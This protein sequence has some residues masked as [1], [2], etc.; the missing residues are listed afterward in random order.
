MNST[1][2]I[3]IPEIKNPSFVNS[4]QA[5]MTWLMT[6]GPVALALSAMTLDGNAEVRDMVSS[7]RLD[8]DA[9]RR[10]APVAVGEEI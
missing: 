9:R 6:R 1:S 2:I 10:K 7:L 4:H 8:V 3:Y 5:I